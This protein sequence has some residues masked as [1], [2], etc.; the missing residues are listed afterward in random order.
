MKPAK[1]GK[2][3]PLAVEKRTWKKIG[4]WWFATFTFLF[5]G[6]YAGHHAE[7]PEEK[8]RFY[9]FGISILILLVWLAAY[10]I[11][12]MLFTMYDHISQRLDQMGIRDTEEEERGRDHGGRSKSY[13]SRPNTAS[14]RAKEAATQLN[15]MDRENPAQIEKFLRGQVRHYTIV[16]VIVFCVGIIATYLAFT[17]EEMLTLFYFWE[18]L[19]I[20]LLFTSIAHI[21]HILYYMLAT[22]RK[23]LDHMEVAGNGLEE[24]E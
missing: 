3:D 22:L 6:A 12:R 24:Q 1:E 5:V 18:Y 20:F 17:V 8:A 16:L 11:S 15:R 4:L 21:F 2:I 13:G 9:F 7:N 14:M 23:R 19:L 10:Y